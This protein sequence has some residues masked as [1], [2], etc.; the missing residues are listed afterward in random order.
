MLGLGEDGHTAS[1][2]P[3]TEALHAKGK[4]VVANYVPQKETW[5]M[6]LTFECINAASHIV[7]YVMGENKQKMLKRV[8]STP[9]SLPA[10]LPVP[11]KTQLSGLPTP[12]L[13]LPANFFY[14]HAHG[15]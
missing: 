10:N 1:L 8:F 5:R 3:N 11:P 7:F 15:Q 6:T 13:I 14:C 2:F 9:A 12:K 4:L